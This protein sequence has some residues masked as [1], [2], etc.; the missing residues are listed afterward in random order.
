MR[1]AVPPRD[2]GMVG[3]CQDRRR[4]GS[5]SDGSQEHD[6]AVA[7]A[8]AVEK[9]KTLRHGDLGAG[10]LFQHQQRAGRKPAAGPR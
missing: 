2:R 6:L 10:V 9:L 3:E 5:G 4:V 7:D 1:V 8:A